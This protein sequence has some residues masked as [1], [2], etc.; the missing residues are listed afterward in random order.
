[1]AALLPEG[2][3]QLEEVPPTQPGADDDRAPSRAMQAAGGAR[4]MLAR[5]EDPRDEDRVQQHVHKG[6]TGYTGIS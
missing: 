1:M 6:C 4:A 2:L 3:S 5:D